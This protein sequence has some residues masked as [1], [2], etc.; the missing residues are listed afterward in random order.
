MM[1]PVIDSPTSVEVVR[2]FHSSKVCHLPMKCLKCAGRHQAKDCT[3]QFE[4][5]LKCANCG[6][7]Q[8]ANWRQC[9]RF[10][11][12]KKAPNHQN[13]GGNIK[14]N[15]PKPSNK[16]INQRNQ[17]TAPKGTSSSQNLKKI[18]NF[19]LLKVNVPQTLNYLPVGVV[20]YVRS[21]STR[22]QL[23]PN[24]HSLTFNSNVQ[25]VSICFWN[26]NGLRPKICEVRDFVSEQNPDLLLVQE[27][28]L[29]PGLD[30]LIANYRLHK[31][32]RNNFPRTR[33]DGDDLE[34]DHLP[35]ILTLYTG[36]ALIKI[37]DQL[38]TNWENFIFL[39]NNKPLPI[40][41]SSSNDDLEIAIRRLGENISEALIEASKPTLKQPP[42][43]LSSEIKAKIR[44]RNRVRK[45][46]QRTR[47]PAVKS[48]FRTLSREITKDIRHFSQFRWKSH[49][50]ALT[51]ETGTLWRKI[52]LFKKPPQT[53]PLKGALGSVAN[54]PLEK[55]EVIADGL[56]KQFEPNTEAENERFTAHTQKIKLFLDAPTCLDLEKK[57]PG[58]SLN[59][60]IM[61][62][63]DNR[64]L[65]LV[66]D[67]YEERFL[68]RMT[69]GPSHDFRNTNH[70]TNNQ[71]TNRNRQENGRD[72]K[73]E[74]RYHNTSR[75][76]RESNRFGGQG[77]GDNRRFNSRC[78][79]GQFDH[80]FNN[81]GGRQGGSRNGA[82][83]GQN[84]QDKYLNFKRLRRVWG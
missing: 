55:V 21:N 67:K 38:S 52:S 81:H 33:A 35:V 9:P 43:K 63:Y 74:T 75:P 84:G 82:F 57:T 14:N 26:A 77:V 10:P 39:L 3:L 73:V 60:W 53:P 32:D 44:D 56:Q 54:H 64:R 70:S 37:P 45:F 28:K 46:W 25:S 4:D 36:S 76:Q 29:Q 51:P 59:F 83:R 66:F 50:A 61:W 31:D 34:S 16:N 8:T 18:I 2:L 80:R 68:N 48:E 6:G 15:N 11:K 79:S 42:L 19:G 1:D 65:R 13:K 30:P 17:N 12:S 78:R 22:A 69:R 23:R 7:E 49:L 20:W 72:T 47:D 62:P 71:F 40:P 5:P 24:A 27:T 58:E 41:P